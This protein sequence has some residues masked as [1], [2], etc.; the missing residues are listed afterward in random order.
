MFTY[1]KIYLNKC[2]YYTIHTEKKHDF[3]KAFDQSTFMIR[4]NSPQT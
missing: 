3:N 4:N 2:A 1:A